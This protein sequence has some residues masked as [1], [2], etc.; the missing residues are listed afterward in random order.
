M[1]RSYGAQRDAQIPP[2]PEL[3]SLD[4]L[5]QADLVRK[6]EISALELTEA[7]IERI[8]RLNPRLNAV[9]TPMYEEAIEA[10]KG[11][12]PRGLF[13]GVPFLLKE[14]ASSAGVPLTMASRFLHG[15]V[16]DHDS[17]LVR[18]YRRAGLVLLGKTN[19]PEFCLVGTAE[20]ELYGPC[21]NPWDETRSPGGSSGGSGAAVA[22]RMV[23][24]AHGSD[25]GGSIRGPASHC[26][27]FGLKPTR[28]RISN[29][30]DYLDWIG[31]SA[32]HALTWSVRDSAALLDATAGPAVWDPYWSPR[33]AK[34][35]LACTASSPEPLRIAVTAQTSRGDV[36]TDCVQAVQETAA[37]CEELGHEL[38]ELEPR[39]DSER[40]VKA[41]IGLYFDIAAWTIEYWAKKLGKPPGASHFELLTWALYQRGRTRSALEHQFGVHEA[42]QVAREV[43]EVLADYDA[44]LLPAAVGAAPKLGT[45]F[46]ASPENP[47]EP[48]EE[49]IERTQASAFSFIA[50]V[51]GNPAMSVPLFWNADGLPIGSQVLGRFGDEATLLRLAAQLEQARPWGDRRPPACV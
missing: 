17:D 43:A 29:A 1:T 41:Y 7:A 44:W 25:G 37:L 30:P 39:Y 36:H 28:G 23:P 27:V 2:K 19:T 34:T 33:S 20:P 32:Q 4:G 16:A 10:A 26:G 50:N 40:L 45:T 5:A 49:I 15:H 35:F 3:A 11:A 18:R 14:H 24:M 13:T 12:L 22:A 46:I 38:T 42:R 6:G 48:F 8:E 51:T 47:L 31:F 21:R 9:V